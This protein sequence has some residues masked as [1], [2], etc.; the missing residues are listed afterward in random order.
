MV[1]E[2]Y[3]YTSADVAKIVLESRKIRWSSPLTL[4]DPAEFKLAVTPPE[5]RDHLISLALEEA[6]RVASGEVQPT[7]MHGTVYRLLTHRNGW[8]RSEFLANLADAI[9]ESVDTH[10][11]NEPKWINDLHQIMIRDKVLCLTDDPTNPTMWANYADNGAGI[12]IGFRNVSAFDSPYSEARPVSYSKARP[13]IYTEIELAKTIAGSWSINMS[14][15]ARR[16]TH[17]KI[18]CWS[19]E[20]E[21][22]I[23]SGQGRAP[24]ENFEDC[25]FNSQELAKVIFGY[26]CPPEERQRIQELAK[27]RYDS[28]EF[29]DSQISPYGEIEITHRSV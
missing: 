12:L 25:E 1:P 27:K 26:H 2:L 3:K 10:L 28:V 20:R 16:I 8:D 24:E 13:S 21:W 15:V 6:W 5:R 9:T 19:H 17:T 14:D 22:R 4:N 7:Q 11:K 23:Y 18:E 29:F